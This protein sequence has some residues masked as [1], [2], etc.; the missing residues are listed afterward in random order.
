MYA[1]TSSHVLHVEFAG[2][3]GVKPAADAATGKG[4]QVPP[5][6][7][8]TYTELWNGISLTYAAAEQ[9]VFSTTYRLSPGANPADI[10]L[11]YSTPLSLNAD[12]SLQMTYETGSMSESAPLA[13]QTINGR[14]VPVQVAF[15]VRGQ[16]LGFAL[17]AYDPAYSLMIDPILTWNTFLGGSGDDSGTA[18]AVDGSGNIYVAGMS[19]AS[20]GVSPVRAYSGGYDAFVAKL[21]PTGAR[22]WN[23]FLGGSGFDSGYAI[24]VD[25]SGN[26]YVAGSSDTNWGSPVRPYT[27]DYDVYAAKLDAN[28]SLTWSTFLGGS[29]FDNGDAITVDGSGNVYVAGDSSTTWGSPVRVYDNAD[30]FA[31]KLNSSGSLTWNTF[32]G[33]SSF[34][35]AY[36]IAVDGSGNIYVAGESWSTWGVDPIRP[37]IGVID[38]FVAKLFPTGGRIWNTFLGG[39]GFELGGRIAL[40]GSGNIYV[41]GTS[42]APWGNP[43][44]PTIGNEDAFAAKL[45][46]TGGLTWN[47]FLGGSGKDYGSSIA[48]DGNGNVYIAGTSEAPWGSPTQ[49]YIAMA[50]GFAAKLSTT[51]NLAWNTF[52]GGSS[53]DN[54]RDIAL[55]EG[56]NIYVTGYSES[57][58]GIP[59]RA[60][61]ANEDA[62]VVLLHEITFLIHLPLVRR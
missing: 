27:A 21:F 29:G 55:Y 60:Y 51:G 50:D 8:V 22:I 52:L 59:I 14:Q 26:V 40:D 3:D 11:R 32:L 56:G 41:T 62:Y 37:F 24:A 31:A 10:R 6:G 4:E 43:V 17:G 44:Q 23:T 15:R 25:G 53:D 61:T 9:G 39:S 49:P 42:A 16:E 33:G 48:V 47:T 45:N 57:T 30:A 28:G 5:L 7:R 58:W 1:A 19:T 20:W 46:S 13:W 54:G 36:D 35:E 34:D 12:G 2:T 38:V 18:I